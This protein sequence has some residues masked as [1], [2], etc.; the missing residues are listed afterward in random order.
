M[1]L[2]R[3]GTNLFRLR[4]EACDLTPSTP[5][6]RVELQLL[7]LSRENSS[8]SRSLPAQGATLMSTSPVPAGSAAPVA[9]PLPPKS[10]TDQAVPPQ[11]AR[12]K[13]Y[14]ATIFV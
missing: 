10:D 6:L 13:S 8:A 7:Q 14:I 4:L 5:S 11:G 9:K 1:A 3:R 2:S 12:W